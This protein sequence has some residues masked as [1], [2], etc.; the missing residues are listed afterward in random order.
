MVGFRTTA[1]PR[2][3][4]IAA[5]RL[6]A[7]AAVGL[8]AAACSSTN[9]G[10]TGA[11][12]ATGGSKATGTGGSKTSGTGGSKT[13]SSTGTGGAQ[14]GGSCSGSTT[15]PPNPP[16]TVD[17][18][19]RTYDIFLPP[20]IEVADGGLP[21]DGGTEDGGGPGDGGPITT[22]VPLF[23]EAPWLLRLAVRSDAL[24]GRGDGQPVQPRG[25]E[26]GHHPGA[27]RTATG[28]GHGKFFWNA[29]NA[30]CDLDNADAERHRLPDGGDRR[31]WRRSTT[32]TRSASSPSATR[33]AGSWSTARVRSG[34]QDRR[35]RLARGRDVPGPEQ[36]RGLGAHRVPPGAGRRRHDRALRR[37]RAPRASPRSRSR[38]AQSTTT[39]DWGRRTSAVRWPTPPSRRSSS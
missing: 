25:A 28:T 16:V 24:A 37:R 39:Q 17:L 21:P 23:L 18:Q 26:A 31:T 38:P 7:L 30:C 19:G 33:T 10:G 34:R 9:G 6:A 5:R 22:P 13:G 3:P 11:S 32:S 14:T 20:G 2:T 29:T 1:S 12:S 8:L 36:V 4:R 15:R 27:C 35:R